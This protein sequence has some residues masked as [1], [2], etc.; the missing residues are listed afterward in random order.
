M[1]P[2]EHDEEGPELTREA[3]ES[4]TDTPERDI[5]KLTELRRRLT[6]IGPGLLLVAAFVGPGTVTTASVAGAT[7]GYAL[8]WAVVFSVVGTIVLQEMSARLGVVTREGLGEAIRTAF[9]HPVIKV[10]VVVLVISSVGIGSSAFQTGNLVGASLGLESLTGIPVYVWAIAVGLGAAALL[11]TGA[12][13]VLERVL[14]VLVGAMALVFLI[15]AIMIRPS[16][17]GIFQGVFT[18]SI[19][20]GSIITIMALIGTTIVL[21]NLFLHASAVKEKW[22]SSTPV[23]RA[24]SEA[25]FDSVLSISIGGLIALAIVI[26]AAGAFF[27]AGIEIT[28]AGQMATQL[29]PLLGVAAG[30]FF[31]AGLFAAGLTSTVANPL[32]S[33]YA[34]CGIL[35]WKADLRN[36]RFKAVWAI[37]M[38]I[39]TV[40]AATGTSPV[41]V[42]VFAQAVNGVLLPL[43]A[44]FLLYVM[45]RRDLLGEF[46]NRTLSNVIGSVI[47]LVITGL[48]IYAILGAFGVIG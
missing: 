13:K 3:P 40:L 38:V 39:G 2:N 17:E 25:R 9:R 43:L 6:S 35:R 48:G 7:Y 21:P 41:E 47:V 36:A 45:N 32:A 23:R 15:T 10:I 44:A 34:I 37:I 5:G 11:G 33:A 4:T 22:P 12:Y 30:Q 18:P 42:I 1:G 20:T 8:L 29:E 19:P 26:T 16:G 31:A 24:L 14:M 28:D 46:R 27:A